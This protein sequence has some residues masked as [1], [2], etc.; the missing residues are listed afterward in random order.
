MEGDALEGLPAL[1]R[2]WAQALLTSPVETEERA[3]CTK[4]PMVDAQPPAQSFLPDAKCCTFHPELPNFHV[5]TFFREAR[6]DLRTGRRVLEAKLRARIGVTPLGIDRP[7][8]YPR[9]L[10]NAFGH[11]LELRC[12]YYQSEGSLTCGIWAAREAT[13]ATWF[14]K[15][16]RGRR[17]RAFWEALRLFLQSVDRSL[18]R[19]CLLQLKLP[20]KQLAAIDAERWTA[21]ERSPMTP[22]RYEAMW[23]EHRFGE[24]RFFA[25]CHELVESLTWAEVRVIG[26]ADVEF[27]AGLVRHAFDELTRA[28]T[29][30]LRAQPTT[31]VRIQRDEY[32]LQTYSPYDL[33][34][35]PKSLI[36]VLELFDGRATDEVVRAAAE[37]GVTL[38]PSTLRGMVEVGLLSEH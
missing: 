22:A 38:D 20:P 17:G 25:S 34:S 5:G 13:C 35:F 27:R 28:P 11:S 4:C 18:A 16:N 3:D 7:P 12:P 1:Y 21:G 24:H 6:P 9:T 37:R 14:C 33:R 10:G 19:W 15:H 31:L 2:G 26:G 23:G 29:G 36:G 30:T 32:V 8:E